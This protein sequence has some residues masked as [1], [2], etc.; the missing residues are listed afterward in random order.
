MPYH[1]HITSVP[2]GEA[3]QWVRERWVGL[4]LPLAQRNATP[5]SLLTSGVLSGPKGL[6]S[7]LLAVVTGKLDRQSG[8][9][10]EVP[11][12]IAILEASHPE[13]A[14]WWRNHTPH[15]LRGKGHFVFQEAVG[16]VVES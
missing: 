15:L 6:L 12:A 3:P 2:P 1:L 16:H 5:L 10:V 13:A 7:C 11:A 8:F 14:A 4:S 9:V